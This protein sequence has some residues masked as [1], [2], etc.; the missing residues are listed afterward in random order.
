MIQNQNS[1]LV[2]KYR[3]SVYVCVLGGGGGLTSKSTIF[4]GYCLKLQCTCIMVRQNI[5]LP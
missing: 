2:K 5:K 4:C 3:T 1:L